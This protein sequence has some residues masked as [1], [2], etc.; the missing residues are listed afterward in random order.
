[1]SATPSDMEQQFLKQLWPAIQNLMAQRLQQSQKVN[2]VQDIDWSKASRDDLEKSFQA[3]L[4]QQRQSQLS[5]QLMMAN[6][7]QSS[8]AHNP[9]RGQSVPT[10]SVYLPPN[11]LNAGLGLASQVNAM[12]SQANAGDQLAGIDAQNSSLPALFARLFQ[13]KKKAAAL[14]STNSDPARDSYDQSGAEGDY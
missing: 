14:I 1:M 11:P 12:R 2:S 13:G 10:G 5:S 3:A 8:A 9:D 7:L 4:N 6:Q